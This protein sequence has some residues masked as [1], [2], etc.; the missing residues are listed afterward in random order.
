[1]NVSRSNAGDEKNAMKTS[2]MNDAA[3]IA[4]PCIS[5]CKLTAQNICSGCGRS[6]AEIGAWRDLSV[7]AKRAV[8]VVARERRKSM[9][10]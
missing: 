8:L 2:A 10:V 9:A 5:V 4:S 7:E 3:E 1:M 6:I